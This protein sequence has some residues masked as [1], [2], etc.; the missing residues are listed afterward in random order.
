MFL[1]TQHINIIIIAGSI[2]FLTGLFIK[3]KKAKKT[4]K[5]DKF[6]EISRKAQKY[7]NRSIFNGKVKVTGDDIAKTSIKYNISPA[8]ILAQ[9]QWESKFGTESDRAMETKSAMGVGL[10]DNG[11]NAVYYKT[12]TEAMLHY[13][14]LMW[15]DYLQQGKK[16]EAELIKNF[17]NKNGHRY[18]SKNGYEDYLN[19][20]KKYIENWWQTA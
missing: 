6:K 15:N 9:G 5:S 4:Y 14:K 7:L 12:W 11:K 3:K 10:Y 16:T 20:Q 8:F 19:T 18:A 2:I 17:V 1:K 13:G